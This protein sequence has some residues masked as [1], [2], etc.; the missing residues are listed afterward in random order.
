MVPAPDGLQDSQ[1]PRRIAKATAPAR[2]PDSLPKRRFTEAPTRGRQ[3]TRKLKPGKL[4]VPDLELVPTATLG[5]SQ[6]SERVLF[7]IPGR[8]SSAVDT[9]SDLTPLGFI[10]LLM[11]QELTHI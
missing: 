10:N 6:L 1:P 9:V 5:D 2:K 4:P 11:R 3:S 7:G 8:I